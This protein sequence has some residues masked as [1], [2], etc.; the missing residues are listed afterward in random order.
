MTWLNKVGGALEANRRERGM[1]ISYPAGCT[2]HIR[3]EQPSHDPLG[4]P[5][6]SP[7]HL[8]RHVPQ[9][10]EPPAAQT[11]MEIAAMAG[12]ST[13]PPSKRTSDRQSRLVRRLPARAPC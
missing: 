8:A 9:S 10:G 13:P 11:C 3:L 5:S 7:W 6:I 2:S 12:Q 4:D 1:H